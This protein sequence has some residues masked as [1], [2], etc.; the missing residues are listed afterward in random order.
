LINNVRVEAE[1]VWTM[2]GVDLVLV[3]EEIEFE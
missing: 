1:G 3:A 2:I